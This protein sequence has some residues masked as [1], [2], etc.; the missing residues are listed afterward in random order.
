[1]TEKSS[2]N[3]WW[4][5][6]GLLRLLLCKNKMA[7]SVLFLVSG[8]VFGAALVENTQPENAGTV[9]R[10]H[11]ID[12]GS[13]GGLRELFR[14]TGEPLPFVAAHRGGPGPGFPENCIAT[15]ENTLQHT[16]AILEID[17]RYTRD[18]AI[19][20]HHDET[21]ERTTTGNG[22]V[23]ARTL[24]ELQALRLKDVTGAVTEFRIPTLDDVLEWARGKTVLVLDQKDVPVEVRVRKIEEHR[25]EAYAMLI[26]YSFEDVSK[27]YELNP[28]I[29]MEVMIPDQE[30]FHRFDK[31]GI[32]WGNIL[33][34]VGHTPPADRELLRMIHAKGSSC[35]VGTS[36]N[37]D[38]EYLAGRE[39]KPGLTSR[40]QALLEF[41]A[42]LIETDVPIEV[43]S[44][45]QTGTSIPVSKSKFLRRDTA[46]Q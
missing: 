32:P 44:L 22:M 42:D 27:C 41:G 29:M 31:T 46:D 8:L 15:F 28:N 35:M 3:S 7:V 40:Y 36:R 13:P 11:R 23:N 16:F 45:L 1:M 43:S 17:P 14:Y 24:E 34:F 5:T 9:V 39:G 18:G 6:L 30:A 37:L 38:R 12:P 25:A 19:I 33:A 20:I 4:K 21:L 10:L 2:E 26:V